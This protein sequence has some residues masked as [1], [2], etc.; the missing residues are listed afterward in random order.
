MNDARRERGAS[1]RYVSAEQCDTGRSRALEDGIALLAGAGIGVALMYLM[2][3]EHGEQRRAYAKRRARAMMENAGSTMSTALG[4][5]AGGAS[6]LTSRLS[7]RMS[8]AYDSASDYASDASSSAASGASS[9]FGNAAGYGKD[10]YSRARHAVGNV[11]HRA[12]DATSDATDRAGGWLSGAKDYAASY[13][14]HVETEADRRRHFWNQLACAVGSLGL[15]AGIVYYIDPDRGRARRAQLA[16]KFSSFTGET[17]DFFRRTGRHVSNKFRG[18]AAE[19]RTMTRNMMGSA[20]PVGDRK[21]TDRIRAE[22]GHATDRAG[23]IDV[24]C[25]SGRVILSGNAPVAEIDRIVA[26]V[27]GVNG[28]NGVDNRLNSGVGV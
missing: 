24:V 22:L 17:G 21:L 10:F 3:P 5:T 8:N 15:G 4:A 6:K 14:P 19:S 20:E 11:F 16:D 9:L 23:D 27:T 25:Y 7:D 13:V 28:V 12:G 2:D 18:Y 26:V 1:G